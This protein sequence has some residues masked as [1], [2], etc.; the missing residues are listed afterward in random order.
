MPQA[1]RKIPIPAIMERIAEITIVESTIKPPC[2]QPQKKTLP[3]TKSAAKSC[4]FQY[5][6]GKLLP[7]LTKTYHMLPWQ[8]A[9]YSL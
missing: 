4:C 2:G 9:N 5:A 1:I 7:V 3:R 8:H 6:P